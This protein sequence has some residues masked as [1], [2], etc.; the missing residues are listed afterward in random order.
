VFVYFIR[1]GHSTHRHNST[2]WWLCSLPISGVARL[3]D[4]WSKQ[5]QWLAL[6]EIMNIKKSPLLIEFPFICLSN[7]KFIEHRKSVFL[8]SKYSFCC[9]LDSAP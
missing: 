1:A 2:N 8:N 9:S 3:F 5:Y 7:K 6:T 4:S